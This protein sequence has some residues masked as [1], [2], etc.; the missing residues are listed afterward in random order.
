MRSQQRLLFENKVAS[1]GS[2]SVACIQQV[3]ATVRQF[4]EYQK[5]IRTCEHLNRISANGCSL[6]RSSTRY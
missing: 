3:K 6:T 2:R 1:L 5:Q 4:A